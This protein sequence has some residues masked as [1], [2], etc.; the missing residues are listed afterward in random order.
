MTVQPLLEGVAA[1][2]ALTMFFC[3]K[4]KIIAEARIVVMLSPMRSRMIFLAD[5]SVFIRSQSFL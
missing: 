5:V 4:E 2:L 1:A 3:W